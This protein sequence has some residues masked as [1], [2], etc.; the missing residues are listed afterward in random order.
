MKSNF[1]KL[2]TVLSLKE[3]KNITGAYDDNYGVCLDP[4]S[5]TCGVPNHVCCKGMCVLPT[6]PVCGL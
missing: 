2:G 5:L 4:F 3:Q 1:S 6:H